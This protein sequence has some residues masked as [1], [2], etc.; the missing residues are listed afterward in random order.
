MA[1]GDDG[2]DTLIGLEAP[3]FCFDTLA[4]VTAGADSVLSAATDMSDIAV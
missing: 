2:T 3:R 4:V 1:D